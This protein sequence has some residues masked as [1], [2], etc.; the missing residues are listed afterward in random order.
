MHLKSCF[1]SAGSLDQF[2]GLCSDIPAVSSSHRAVTGSK[3]GGASKNT[4]LKG[5]FHLTFNSLHRA[6]WPFHPIY[7]SF[8]TQWWFSPVKHWNAVGYNSGLHRRMQ[9][10]HLKR[11]N[12]HQTMGCLWFMQ[13][14]VPQKRHISREQRHMEIN[15]PVSREANIVSLLTHKDYFEWWNWLGTCSV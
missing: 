8:C 7:T 13:Q 11:Q 5:Q 10:P 12:Q 15:V 3:G 1:F 6:A 2:S 4:S 14:D 9:C